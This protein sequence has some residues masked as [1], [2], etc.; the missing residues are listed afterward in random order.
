MSTTRKHFAM[1]TYG[2]AAFAFGGQNSGGSD[3]NSMERWNRRQGWV[4][5]ASMP[6][7][8]FRFCAVSDEMHNKIY[9]IGGYHSHAY[10]KAYQYTISSNSWSPMWDSS[11]YRWA[12]V[13]DLS[14]TNN[15]FCYVRLLLQDCTAV[16]I[17]KKHTPTNQRTLWVSNGRWSKAEWRTPVVRDSHKD[18]AITG[19]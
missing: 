19:A 5:M 6:Y 15:S 14:S 7:T 12:R 13:R 8:N 18:T 2:D 1:L 10:Y 3:L 16:I 9:M 17:A 4:G 11:L